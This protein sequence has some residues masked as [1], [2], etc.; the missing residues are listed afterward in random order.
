MAEVECSFDA[1]Q[2]LTETFDFIHSSAGLKRK[3]FET[4]KLGC[5]E[6]GKPKNYEVIKD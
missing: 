3:C 1:M 5:F 4:S 2:Q 6:I